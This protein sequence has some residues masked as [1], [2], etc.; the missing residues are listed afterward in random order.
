MFFVIKKVILCLSTVT[1]IQ[2]SELRQVGTEVTAKNFKVSTPKQFQGDGLAKRIED[3]CNRRWESV[4]ADA[5]NPSDE[6][7][8]RLTPNFILHQKG[9][10]MMQV[11][12]NMLQ[13]LDVTPDNTKDTLSKALDDLSLIGI[14]MYNCFIRGRNPNLVNAARAICRNDDIIMAAMMDW[15]I[16]N[17]GIGGESSRA[18]SVLHMIKNQNRTLQ[19]NFLDNLLDKPK[20]EQ[21]VE[22]FW[23]NILA[24]QVSPDRLE[25]FSPLDLQCLIDKLVAF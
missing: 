9:L 5:R 13:E 17:G 18:H 15:I 3:D 11:W 1:L 10:R 20:E 22:R 23:T 7:L 6:A 21:N 4:G 14:G 24:P 16:S 19:R 8:L 12:Q 25:G 2:A